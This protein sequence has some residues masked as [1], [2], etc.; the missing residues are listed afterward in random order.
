[1][2][3]FKKLALSI[4]ISAI[5]I[6]FMLMLVLKSDGDISKSERRKLMKAPTFSVQKVLDKR[7]FP[8]YEKYLLDQFPFRDKLRSIKAFTNLELLRKKD[9]DGIFYIADNI[10]KIADRLNQKQVHLATKKIEAIAK[11]HPEAK[12]YYYALIPDKISFVKDYPVLDCKALLAILQAEITTAKYIDIASL[13]TLNDYYRTDPHWSAAKI[14]KVAKKI[15]TAI[16]GYYQPLKNP[17]I[18]SLNNYYG[19]YYGQLAL[20]VPAENME[21]INSSSFDTVSV[22]GLEQNK[23]IKVYDSANFSNVDPY[24]FFLGGAQPL[25]YIEN[26]NA[27]TNRELIIFRDS[28]GSSLA[29]LLVENYKKISLV[30]I[31]YISSKTIDKLLDYKNADVLFIYSSRLYNNGGILK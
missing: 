9:N 28:F 29:P 18:E 15:C 10:F 31:R 11:N 6:I 3:K 16:N 27:T 7:Y 20:D 22:K 8:N 4:L 24:D 30:D 14:E 1:M 2:E 26:K 13:M 12:G 23:E 25:V 19:A 5:L 21:Y 17:Q